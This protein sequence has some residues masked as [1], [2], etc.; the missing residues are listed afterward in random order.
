MSLHALIVIPYYFFGALAILSFLIVLTRIFRINVSINP[1]VGIAIVGSL[2]G[3]TVTLSW[4][5]VSV[6]D[7]GFMGLLF[8]FADSM[9]SAAIDTLLY[10]RLPVHLD[11]ELQ[12]V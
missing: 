1:L 12:E 10:K 9:L 11:T 3:L 5:G 2:V 4:P 6:E 8:L 7:L